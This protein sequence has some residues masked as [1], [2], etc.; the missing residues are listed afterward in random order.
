MSFLKRPKRGKLFFPR[1]EVCGEITGAPGQ[2]GLQFLNGE[3]RRQCGCRSPLSLL[4]LLPDAWCLGGL[5]TD[6][7]GLRILQ[8][9]GCQ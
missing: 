4:L 7:G 3:K 2:R 6:D 5:R 1:R 9:P 8:Q